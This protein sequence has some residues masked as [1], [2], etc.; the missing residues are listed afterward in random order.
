MIK[1]TRQVFKS[2]YIKYYD[3]TNPFFRSM[4]ERVY[5][6]YD[7][8]ISEDEY[9]GTTFYNKDGKEV[10]D[11]YGTEFIDLTSLKTFANEG[12]ATYANVVELLNQVDILFNKNIYKVN[13]SDNYL[14][15]YLTNNENNYIKNENEK[16]ELKNIIENF[17]DIELS[18]ENSKYS[19][20][21]WKGYI[22]I[23]NKTYSSIE[24]YNKPITNINTSNTVNSNDK[25]D[26]YAKDFDISVLNEYLGENI[27]YKKTLELLNKFCNEYYIHL[28][29]SESKTGNNPGIYVYLSKNSSADKML[30]DSI[31][32]T[33]KSNIKVFEDSVEAT[34]NISVGKNKKYGD[35]IFIERND[36]KMLRGNFEITSKINVSK[37]NYDYIEEFMVVLQSK[38]FI[39]KI[40]NKYNINISNNVKIWSMTKNNFLMNI[41][42]EG[43]DEEQ[44]NEYS[45][46]VFTTF[47]EFIKNKYNLDLKT[48]TPF[49]EVIQ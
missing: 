25:N 13:T 12:D 28:T 5:M 35:Y 40:N 6:S 46:Y 23:Y 31:V 9:G 36:L 33:I 10:E 2:N 27:S 3:Y 18:K 47:K 11:V 41:G 44:Y 19:I 32:S 49:N 1:E 26:N 17:K 21:F 38:E 43:I 29:N 37:G 22:A 48:T 7:D 14:F 34:Y 4:Q 30:K 8:T 45:E 39:D 24:N 16:Q 15:I 20:R 42:C